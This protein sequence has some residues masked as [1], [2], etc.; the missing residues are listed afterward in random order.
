[1][2]QERNRFLSQDHKWVEK[3]FEHI[4]RLESIAH[5]VGSIFTPHH[6]D[7]PIERMV[8]KGFVA[9]VRKLKEMKQQMEAK[10]LR[11]ALSS[12]QML[13]KRKESS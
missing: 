2:Q 5:K 13:E 8:D 11:G 3:S 4:T 1:M 10:N 6:L 12:E 9:K 7:F